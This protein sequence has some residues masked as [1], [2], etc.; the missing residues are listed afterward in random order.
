MTSLPQASELLTR[1]ITVGR[2][3]R[4]PGLQNRALAVGR[5]P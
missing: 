5:V 1:G 4:V 2:P 3:V